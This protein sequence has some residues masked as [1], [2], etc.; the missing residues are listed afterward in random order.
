MRSNQSVNPTFSIFTPVYN[1]ARWL[2]GAIESVLAQS[3]PNWELVIGDNASERDLASIV[4][5]YPDERIR[6]RRWER[7][8]GIADNHNRTILLC[9]NDWLQ[10]LSADD[11]LAPA[12]LE[13]MAV[14][15]EESTAAGREPALVITACRPVFEDGTEARH[16]FSGSWRLKH[17][18]S[19]TYEPAQW[20]RHVAEPGQVPWNV[21]SVAL[22]RSVWEVMGGFFREEVGLSIDVDMVL[23]ASA[24][25]PVEY[26]E[27]ELLDYTVRPGGI[28][29]ELARS[30]RAS[31]RLTTLGAAL[32][33]GLAVHEAR[34]PVSSRERRYVERQVASTFV[35]RALQQ[36]YLPG[37]RGRHGA[38][39]DLRRAFGWDR[40]WFLSPRQAVRAAMAVG[41][42]SRVIV[43]AKDR[44]TRTGRVL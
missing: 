5:G 21:G 9:R 36:R 12:C 27:D 34:R 2:P 31:R 44:F 7:H 14:R 38:L 11:R 6:F 4:A 15:I 32:L 26:L 40:L 19:G 41:A 10:I 17:L 18:P 30:D 20:L 37:G 43:Q 1:D 39:A 28:N 23:R 33:S 25:G 22:A 16:A 24:Y 13:R 8:T 3:Y 42:P 29:K 35:G